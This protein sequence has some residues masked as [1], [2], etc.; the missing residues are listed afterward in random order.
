VAV[1]KTPV[2]T[3]IILLALS[4]IS[5]LPMIVTASMVSFL[6]TTKITLIRSQRHRQT[7]IPEDE[8]EPEL[9][10]V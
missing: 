6:L 7:N 5:M 1:T 9:A 10:E 3:S 4:G 2:S 8:E